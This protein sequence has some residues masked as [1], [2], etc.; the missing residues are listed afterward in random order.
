MHKK[1]SII[2]PHKH[3]QHAYVM[4]R[5][6]DSYASDLGLIRCQIS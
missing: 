1:D 4:V 6:A 5:V 3:S 2:A